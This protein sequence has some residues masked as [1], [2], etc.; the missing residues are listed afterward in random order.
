MG[1]L[2]ANFRGVSINLECDF[3]IEANK[4]AL[5]KQSLQENETPLIS[6]VIPTYQAE[7]TLRRT[8]SSVTEQTFQSYEALVMDGGSTDGTSEI[9]TA[10]SRQYPQVQFLSEPDEGV[11]DAMN[12]GIARARGKWLYFLGSDDN[13]F[14]NDTFEQ[15]AK[16]LQDDV[17]IVYGN[18]VSTR[19]NGA[20]DGEFN[21]QKII[22]KNICH[23]AIFFHRIVFESLGVFNNDYRFAGDWEFNFRWMLS[24]KIKSRFIDQIIATYADGG[25]SS[26]NRDLRWEQDRLLLYVYYGRDSIDWKI[27]LPIVTKEMR[28]S[29]RELRPRLFLQSSI[30]LLRTIASQC[31]QRTKQ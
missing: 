3:Q 27:R 4:R 15:V 17:R 19:W 20:Y 16:S 2:K 30:A 23:Q 18:V 14:S 13:L 6:V 24:T 31:L 26:Q 5:M 29:A 8:L 22:D 7:S 10:F 21:R 25:L 28:R 1:G 11:F 12:K 9:A